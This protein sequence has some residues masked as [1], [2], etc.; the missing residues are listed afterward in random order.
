MDRKNIYRVAVIA[1]LAAAVV[2]LLVVKVRRPGSESTIAP[3]VPAATLP[4]PAA[5]LPRLLDLG[6]TKCQACVAMEAVLEELRRDHAGRLQ[7]DFIDVFVSQDSAEQYGITLIP[8]QIFY[9]AAGK[10]LFRHQGFIAAADVVAK[11]RE[12]GIAL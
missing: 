2:V 1:L 4:A 7:V 6:S 8:T 11:F 9:D 3:S 12:L 10:E 5:G